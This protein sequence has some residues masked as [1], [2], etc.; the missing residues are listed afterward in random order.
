VTAAQTSDRV[1]RAACAQMNSRDDV[2]ENVRV[3]VGLVEAA[4]DRGASLVA[5]PETWA[6]KGV[7][8]GILATAEAPDGPSNAAVAAAASRR[9]MWLLAGSIYEPSPLPDRVY[10]TSVLFD[11]NGTARAV[12]RKIHLFDVVSG[13][14]AY[15]ESRDVAPGEEL[16]TADVA[17]PGAAALRLGLTI[18]YD[19]RF[20]EL[21]RALAL[22]GA[23]VLCVPAAFTAHTGAAHWDVLVRARAVEN[24]CFVLAPDQVGEHLPGRSCHG[25]SCIVDPWGAVLARVDD[26]VGVCVADIDLARLAEVR[27]QVPSLANRRPDVYGT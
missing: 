21:Y 18:C 14:V 22:R 6:F 9:G 3:A 24:T 7:R 15:E 2:A 16:V 17:V 23:A 19:L 27:T 20:P 25:Q 1:L 13:D 10:N 8:E 11:P 4:A 5:L 26:G 12:Y